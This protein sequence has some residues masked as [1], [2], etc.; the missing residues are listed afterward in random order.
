M[1]Y[2]T[3]Q[4]VKETKTNYEFKGEGVQTLMVSTLSSFA[5]LQ[6]LACV[7]QTFNYRGLGLSWLSNPNPN[8]VLFLLTCSKHEQ[9]TT[10]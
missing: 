2:I 10:V 9:R 1:Q 6:L 3:T 5:Y 7:Y 8:T 4:L